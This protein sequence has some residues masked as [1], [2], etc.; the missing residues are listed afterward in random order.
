M[1]ESPMKIESYFDL[2]ENNVHLKEPLIVFDDIQSKIL[3]EPLPLILMGS[4][5]SGKTTLILEKLKTLTGNLLYVTLSSYLVHN[6]RNLYYK[7]QDENE[8]QELDFLS[9]KELL[10][11]IQIPE[12][13]EIT[14]S[15]FLQWFDRQAKA[16]MIKDGRKLYEEFRGVICG[17]YEGVSYLSQS[18]YENL[19]VRQS[20]YSSEERKGVYH[21]FEKYLTFLK[22]NNTFD[23]SILAYEYRQKIRPFYDAIIVDEVQD[24]TNSQLSFI[25]K[26]LKKR[27]KFLLCG[28]ANQIVHPN[29]FSW[30]KLKSYLYEN[31][32]LESVGLT[33]LTRNYRNTP[34]VTECANKILKIKRAQFGSVDKESHYLIESKSD[35]KGQVVCIPELGDT[36]KSLNEKIRRSTHYAILILSDDQKE[37][38]K[39]YFD[40]PLIFSIQEAKGLEYENIIL[41]NFISGEPRYREMVKGLDKKVFHQ[42][43][44]YGRSKD[45]SDKSFES[46]KFYINALYVA[47]TRSMSHVYFIEPTPDHPLIELLDLPVIGQ[48]FEIKVL[49]SSLEEWQKE[50]SRL[51]KQGKTEQAEAI[52]QSILKYQT[53]S[54]NSLDSEGF[55][56]L[57]QRTLMEKTDSKQDRLRLLEYAMLYGERVVLLRLKSEGLNAASHLKKSRMIMEDKYFAA[58]QYK[59]YRQVHE[60]VMKYGLE[61]LNPLG[62]TPLMGAAYCGNETLAQELVNLGSSLETYDNN[63]RNA[64]QIALFRAKEDPKFNETKLPTLYTLLQPDSLSLDVGGHLIKIDASRAEYFLVHI[65]LLFYADLL[66]HSFVFKGPKE[67]FSAGQLSKIMARYTDVI[68]PSYRKKRTYLSGLLSRNEI[69]SHYV[70]NRKLFRRVAHGYYQFNPEIKLKTVQEWIPIHQICENKDIAPFNDFSVSIWRNNKIREDLD[71]FWEEY[72]E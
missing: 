57:K 30:S 11:T 15:L 65:L 47:V 25:L 26:M 6:A 16:P 14:A 59:N 23:T 33:C 39:K 8:H 5:G 66:L 68:L 18:A 32:N 67:G 51:L 4:A 37:D 12:G 43:F 27:Q 60:N 45:K 41:F 50:A 9:F 40:T 21:L 24:F 19:G 64:F 13:K 31:D 48:E 46:Y 61:H 62:F 34:E 72:E 69:E 70:P 63:Y 1:S 17:S 42:D 56:K 52:E 54:W 7:E 71:E 55:Q 20:I 28:D 3:Y 29:F 53:P 49:E 38:V 58:Y 35:N 10:E 36:L 44:T 2:S 22:E